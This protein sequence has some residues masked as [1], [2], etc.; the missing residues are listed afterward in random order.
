MDLITWEIGRITG[1][2]S[3][4][5][6]CISIVS[7]LALRTSVL[8]F[9]A[10][11]RALRALHDWTLWL[12]I[13]LGVA[14]VGALFIDQTAR[15]E[16]IDLVVPFQTDYGQVAIGLGTISLDLFVIIVV[17]SWLRRRMNNTLWTWIHRTSYIAFLALFLHAYLGGTDFDSPIVS[18]ISWSA[19]AGLGLFAVSRIFFGRL[20]E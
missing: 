8:D 10:K 13:P 4:A 11:N 5:A 19:A 1:L 6:L 14:H 18:A 12:W 9:L 20:A 2:A 17:T 15:L 16:L 7:G 3:Y